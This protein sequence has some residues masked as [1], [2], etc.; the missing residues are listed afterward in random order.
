M[1]GDVVAS[2]EGWF[3]KYIDGW[4]T[5][6]RE[7]ILQSLLRLLEI[8]S[9]GT[10]ASGDM[11]FGVEVDRALG[12][13][14]QEALRF[15]MKT[16]NVDG[17]AVHAE[18][19]SG[20]ELVMA[21][22][23]V[24]VVPIGQGWTRNPLGELAGGYVYGRGAQDNKGPTVACL[25][26]LRAI[27]ESGAILR[28]R[29]RHVVGGNEESGFA[30]VRHY[31]Q[32]EEY[33]TYGFSPD[34][35]FP[36]V[37]A[38]KGTMNIQVT[39]DM[40][41]VKTEGYRETPSGGAECCL[42]EI[43]GGDRPNVVP[44]EA[45]AKLQVPQGQEGDIARFLE[46]QIP[47]CRAIVGGPVP[48]KFEFREGPGTLAIRAVGKAAHASTPE[49]G[50]NAVAGLL[51][52]LAS[53]GGRLN[54]SE[55]LGF[56]AQVSDTAGRGFGIAVSDDI[57]GPLTCNLGVI[58]SVRNPGLVVRAIY[59]CRYP[60]KASGDELREKVLSCPKLPGVE[61]EV[62]R[63]GR[64]HYTDPESFL[65]KTLLR[66]YREET[67]DFSPPVAIGGGTYARVIPGGVAYGP[68]K[69]GRE[70]TAHQA[71]ERI[72]VEDLMQLVRIYARA[73]YVLAT[74]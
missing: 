10:E 12:F 34:G 59:N 36:V 1:A 22:T 2:S 7:E 41:N 64:P 74:A 27:L 46:S 49:K 14:Q 18:I 44:L 54:G 48:L 56:M 24:D 55:K 8:P 71:D 28:R 42:L 19:G 9:V 5:A 6:H 67:G 50:T 23:H 72:S 33:P 62:L 15:G 26:A 51:Y 20:N 32:V 63:V 47:S 60:V 61:I 31:F 17:Y 53:L 43:S 13:F 11:P 68:V 4:I 45:T 73:L 65:V 69:P 58:T 35:V 21:L 52:L 38:E 16:R 29:I 66:I 40:G 30:C 37:F 57:S 25:Y 39:A 70:E 3:S